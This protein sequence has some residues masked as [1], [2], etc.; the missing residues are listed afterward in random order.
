MRTFLYEDPN[1]IGRTYFMIYKDGEP[2][3]I[4]TDSETE[5]MRIIRGLNEGTEDR[6]YTYHKTYERRY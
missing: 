5:A 6:P 1:R 4:T 2:T 3:S